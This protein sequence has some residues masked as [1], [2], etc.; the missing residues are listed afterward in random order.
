MKRNLLTTT[1]LILIVGLIGCTSAP[2]TPVPT[3]VQS[4]DP[5]SSVVSAEGVVAPFQ[6]ASLAF[7]IGGRVTE[8]KVKEGDTVKA[9]DVIAALDSTLL[10]KQV[11]QAEATLHV[12]QRQLAQLKAGA[13]SAE[14]QAAKDALTAARAAYDKVKAGPSKEQIAQLKATLDNTQ[15]TVRQAQAAYDRIGGDANF[16]GG[17]APERLVLQQAYNNLVAA[18]AAYT[19][20]ASHPTDSELKQAAAAVTQA[21][22]AVARLDPTPEAIALAEAQ[23]AQVQSALEIA[24]ASVQD[25]TLTAPFAGTIAQISINLGDFASPGAPVIIIG[26][27]SNLRIETT[28]LSEVD[29]AKVKIGQPVKITLDALPN[30]A[31]AGT[32]SRIAPLANEA[33]GDKVFRVWIDLKEGVDAGLRWGMAVSVEINVEK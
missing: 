25:A 31:F 28:D 16:L 2:A 10:Q 6:R 27:L 20:A 18:Q 8:V 15:A 19:E 13:S 24:K 7:K 32:V 9:G 12:T 30:Q 33:R 5:G 1:F 22:S 26:D 3:P 17:A 11:Q 4:K 14:R 23:V 29:V 21:E